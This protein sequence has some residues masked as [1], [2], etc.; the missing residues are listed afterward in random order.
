MASVF[1]ARADTMLGL[2]LEESMAGYVE[3]REAVYNRETSFEVLQGR[4][5]KD[6][7]LYL[8]LK[9]AIDIVVALL[10]VLL[11]DA[12][13]GEDARAYARSA[14]AIQLPCCKK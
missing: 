1:H 10:L 9:R 11:F 13:T 7:R 6:S 12:G 8:F 4:E 5:V 2:F 14:P 3:L